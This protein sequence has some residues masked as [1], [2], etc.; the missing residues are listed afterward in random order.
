MVTRERLWLDNKGQLCATP[1]VTGVLLAAPGQDIPA[2]I[3]DEHQLSVGKGG[4]ILQSGRPARRPKSSP[5]AIIADR[6]LWVT[7]EGELVDE[8]PAIGGVKLAEVGEK[9]P[10]GYVVA[11]KLSVKNGKVVGGKSRPKPTNKARTIP[12]NK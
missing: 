12:R 4:A 11:H 2:P 6:S 10:L 7:P 9:V 3:A 5:D 8:P 1:P